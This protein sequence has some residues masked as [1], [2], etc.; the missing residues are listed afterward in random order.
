MLV[1]TA[2]N[3]VIFFDIKKGIRG[4]SYKQKTRTMFLTKVTPRSFS[5]RQH[6]HRLHGSFSHGGFP[7]AIRRNRTWCI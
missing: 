6:S 1:F 5:P 4:N 2:A 7:N 3:V